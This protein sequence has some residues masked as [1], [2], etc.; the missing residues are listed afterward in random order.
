MTGSYWCVLN[1]NVQIIKIILIC[2][3]VW[4]SVAIASP[5]SA[6]TGR[7]TSIA[8][9]DFPTYPAIKPNVEF[10]IDIFTKFS[11]SQGVMH[12][13]RNLGIIYDII[14]LDAS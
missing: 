12:D 13:T 11:K 3:C 6:A 8:A 5:L 1:R 7:D 2:V 4:F 10:W 9:P 14:N